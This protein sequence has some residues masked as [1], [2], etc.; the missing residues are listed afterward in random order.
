M[1][2]SGPTPAR[3][4]LGVVAGVAAMLLYAGQFVVS[5]WS[6][7]GTLS[8]WDLAMLRFT[9]AGALLLPVVIHQGVAS[10][11]GI[12][13]RRALA[14]AVTAG[15]P[16]T[17]VLYAGLAV[18]PAS[19]GAVIISGATPVV[20]AALVWLWFGRR[21]GGARLAG[22]TAIIVGLL[23]VSWPGVTQGGDESPWAGDGLFAAASV[24]W[25]LYTVLAR[26]WRVDPLRGTA[27][28]WVIALAYSPIY[29]GLAGS[30]LIQAPPGEVLFQAI[31]Q[32]VGVAILALL[33]YTWAI[34]VLGPVVASLL[35]PLI[36]VFGVLLAVPVLGEVPGPL[37]VVG[38]LAVSV[39]MVLAA[40]A[41][42]S[43]RRGSTIAA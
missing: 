27:V 37:Q 2:A 11:A 1:N 16:Y 36:P 15:A 43:G 22:L 10:A 24:L 4:A 26:H 32:G 23:L 20:S 29:A 31:Y 5:R 35:M 38:M 41:P 30:R 3:V 6:L 19:H 8:L 28:V 40:A 12:G 42:A 13:W 39:G 9:A 17:L 34:R 18:A 21:P 25:G 7:Q 14:L 33:L